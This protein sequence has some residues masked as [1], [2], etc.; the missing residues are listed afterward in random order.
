[1]L[2]RQDDDP[3]PGAVSIRLGASRADREIMRRALCR[4]TSAELVDLVYLGDLADAPSK[5]K[6]TAQG[7]HAAEL[8]VLLYA[9]DS[10]DEIDAEDLF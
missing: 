10:I 3:G 4:L 9:A 8:L 5:A 7:H 2:A 6:L 1:M